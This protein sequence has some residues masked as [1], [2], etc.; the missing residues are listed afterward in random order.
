MLKPYEYVLRYLAKYPKTEQELRIKLFQKW[1]N[2]EQVEK[3]F[4]TL[5]KQW[6]LN[7]QKFT[8]GYLNSQIANKGKPVFLI[9]Q[10][11]KQK[12]ISENM[13]NDYLKEHEQELQEWIHD[14]IKKEIKQYKQKG[15]EWFDI[16]QKLMKK[17]YKLDDIKSV[18]E[19]R[20]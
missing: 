3:T 20:K 9:K 6:Y 1:Y 15:I 8:E 10:K 16:I 17:W 5:K 11:L 4:V 14:R 12:G 19:K 13:I 18:I 7:D 2:T